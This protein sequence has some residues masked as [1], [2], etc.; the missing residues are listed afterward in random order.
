MSWIVR[1]PRQFR[2][3]HPD[4]G[5]EA[6]W[7]GDLV[8]EEAAE[9]AAVDTTNQF[10]QEPA[11]RQGVVAVLR[12]GWVRRRILG[13]PR[14]DS[15]EVP[16]TDTIV[17]NHLVHP[18]EPDHPGGVGEELAH[19][20]AFLAVLRILRPVRRHRLVQVDPAPVDQDLH[21]DRGQSLR[22][23][24]QDGGG[25]LAPRLARP[26]LASPNVDHWL[27]FDIRAVGATAATEAARAGD[28]RIA[29]RFVPWLDH[30]LGRERWQRLHQRV[31]GCS[32][33]G[34]HNCLHPK[35]SI[36]GVLTCKAGRQPKRSRL[37][38]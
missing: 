9:R 23:R 26:S 19:Q 20:R 13:E 11:D 38:A 22:G 32:R 16:P 27:A 10:R 34:C 8:G 37:K 25:L 15:V 4:P 33:A 21:T 14:G 18:V 24:H 35:L 1:H 3:R 6:E 30:P 28:E 29:H 17:T 12:A 7:R 2:V 5:F 36:R 31:L